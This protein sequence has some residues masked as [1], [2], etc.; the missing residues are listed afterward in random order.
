MNEENT[1]SEKK[2]ERNAIM[3]VI[4]LENK[5][6]P[7]EWSFLREETG[8]KRKMNVAK[9]ISARFWLEY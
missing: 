9:E 7:F 1:L 5:Y 8:I 3:F 4:M 6:M 2:F